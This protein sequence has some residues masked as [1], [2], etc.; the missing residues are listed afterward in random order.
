M[1]KGAISA[2]ISIRGSVKITKYNAKET[3]LIYEENNAF[4]ST[5][6]NYLKNALITSGNFDPISDMIMRYNSGANENTVSVSAQDV[7][8]GVCKFEAVWGTGTEYAN[9]DRF[10]LLASSVYS[11]INVTD[12]TKEDTYS[13]TIEWT[14]TFS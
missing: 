11:I 14:V 3:I 10:S 7:G 5:G 9:I 6:Y 13:L 2:D 1:Y 12:F 8:V 4:Q